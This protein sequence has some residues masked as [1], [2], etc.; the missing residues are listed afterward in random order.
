MDLRD[1]GNIVSAQANYIFTFRKIHSWWSCRIKHFLLTYHIVSK[2]FSSAH[3]TFA[4][5]RAPSVLLFTKTEHSWFDW[6]WLIVGPATLADNLFLPNPTLLLNVSLRLHTSSYGSPQSLTMICP[7]TPCTTDY[8]LCYCDRNWTPGSIHRNGLSLCRGNLLECCML[9]P[10]LVCTRL[11]T[12]S[13]THT[14]CLPYSGR[15]LI[16]LRFRFL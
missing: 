4:A 8:T 6:S 9:L 3:K 5:F 15:L 12:S 2:L 10:L 11:V 16:G 13:D 7:L 1:F 14:Q